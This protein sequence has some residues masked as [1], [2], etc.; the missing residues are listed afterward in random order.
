MRLPR[1]GRHPRRK[2]E[3]EGAD[4]ALGEPQLPGRGLAHL[5][6][7]DLARDGHRELVDDLDVAGDLVVGELSGAEVPQRLGREG[8]RSVL[9]PDPGAQLLPYFSSGT[10][11]TWASRMSGCV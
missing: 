3:Q 5:D 8:C 1:R 11:I 2:R 10:P 7:A 6:L 4:D 9:H